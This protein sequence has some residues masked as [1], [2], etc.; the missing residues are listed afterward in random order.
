MVAIAAAL[1]VAQ[2]VMGYIGAR[3]ANKALADQAKQTQLRL[4]LEETQI[5][6]QAA[7]QIR[8]RSAIGTMAMAEGAN[9][10]GAQTG[11]S[12]SM[13]LAAMA[14][15]MTLD[16]EALKAG[17]DAQIAGIEFQ[18]RNAVTAAR[19]RM[20]DPALEAAGGFLKGFG[21]GL[22]LETGLAELGILK[23]EANRMRDISPIYEDLDA[24][25]L[26]VLAL[27]DE[28]LRIRLSS[29]AGAARGLLDTAGRMG[30]FLGALSGGIGGETNP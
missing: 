12:I 14:G 3:S 15:D 26:G 5:R 22:S 18:K 20:Q 27:V 2:G 11:L 16:T 29:S 21:Q 4:N 6:I 8:Q 1:G 23:H 19:T 25:R 7:D 24:G 28:G 13:R 30:S 9:Q 17:L 10:F